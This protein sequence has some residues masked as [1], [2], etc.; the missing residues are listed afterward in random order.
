M[1]NIV[2]KI[3]QVAQVLR[4]FAPLALSTFILSTIL[5]SIIK[6]DISF[7]IYGT[8]AIPSFIA[9]LVVYCIKKEN[10]SYQIR[11]FLVLLANL[12]A[13][14]WSKHNEYSPCLDTEDKFYIAYSIILI[15]AI[16]YFAFQAHKFLVISS[17]ENKEKNLF[18]ERIGDLEK[19]K[20][21]LKNTNIHE[22][23]ISS[24]W[25]EGKTFLLNLLKQDVKNEYEFITIKV[26]SCTLDN[27]EEF[28]LEELSIIFRKEG[29]YTPA[30]SKLKNFFKKINLWGLENFFQQDAE[31]YTLSYDQ[32]KFLS[33]QLKKKII[34]NIED[35]DRI[36]D[37]HT[38]IKLFSISNQISSNS[39]KV[40]YQYGEAELLN[41]LN[42]KD[43]FYLEKYIPLRVLLTPIP[44]EKAIQKFIGC[45]KYT[46]NAKDFSFLFESQRFEHPVYQKF[47]IS[48]E[49]G[50]LFIQFP[51]RKTMIFLEE[52]NLCV[53]K[54]KIP[55]GE[56]KIVVVF[57]LIKQFFYD[58]F[59]EMQYNRDFDEL[60]IFQLGENKFSIKE[61][62]SDNKKE[63]ANQ[64]EISSFNTN[65]NRLLLK[66]YAL[67]DY[68]L[69]YKQQDVSPKS[70]VFNAIQIKNHN[71]KINETLKKLLFAG[72]EGLSKLEKVHK[73]AESLL[74]NPDSFYTEYEK[75]SELRSLSKQID[76]NK[77]IHEIV[78]LSFVFF[79]KNPDKWHLLIQGLFNEK[80]KY[81]SKFYIRIFQYGCIPNKAIFIEIISKLANL[82]VSVNF[83]KDEYYINFLKSFL[84]F[85]TKLGYA[86]EHH[87][88]RLEKEVPAKEISSVIDE[89]V[90]EI[91]DLYGNF[92]ITKISIEIQ[93]IKKFLEFNKKVVS[94]Q[95][96]KTGNSHNTN[97]L[98]YG[99]YQKQVTELK[100]LDTPTRNQKLEELYEQGKLN[101]G[102]I[103]Y[104]IEKI[105]EAHLPTLWT[106]NNIL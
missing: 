46:I 36:A 22:I 101:A 54:Y 28:I 23:G 27:V 12:V 45:S 99:A 59:D 37:K 19:I 5:F 2:Q 91:D 100:Y 10:A 66:L 84:S 68:K 41:I 47:K 13:F 74:N 50:P 88:W 6:T 73:I 95:T 25:G 103:A 11:F 97:A 57:H 104:I 71:E 96:Q 65:T 56:I 90:K 94:F 9:C 85:L 8:A 7:E 98:P 1:T 16:C 52:V 61:L 33:E 63:S 32:I 51:L 64:I 76:S 62:L 44:F 82:T 29:F 38:I 77:S 17:E 39:I 35:I 70:N 87:L 40:I 31:S 80:D 93:S 106:K 75:N 105:E 43:H 67:L 18:E 72:N 26:M 3:N 48:L 14:L 53:E 83:S 55:K 60:P 92:P 102:E 20:E 81:F 58:V 79:E 69:D 30:T 86:N 49:T 42:I 78:M 34:L 15:I 21:F 24:V 4:H 89:Y